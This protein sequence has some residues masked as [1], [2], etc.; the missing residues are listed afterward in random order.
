[1][2]E[3]HRHEKG[4]CDIPERN[5]KSID[6]R[7][8]EITD[9]RYPVLFKES[10]HYDFVYVGHDVCACPWCSE[11]VTNKATNRKARHTVKADLL[12]NTRQIQAILND[13]GS[14]SSILEDFDSTPLDAKDIPA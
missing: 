3:T 10:C 4:F 14:E 8:K 9:G 1:M 2:K 5:M 13:E 7:H 6:E 12:K 11:K